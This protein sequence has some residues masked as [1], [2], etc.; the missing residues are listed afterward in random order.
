MANPA[1]L[2]NFM[3]KQFEFAAHIRNPENPAPA[4]VDERRMAVYRELFYNNIDDQLAN[5]FPVIRS[6]MNDDEWHAMVRD[7]YHRHDCHT[8]LFMEIPQEFISYI[9]LE[10]D[11]ANDYPFLLELAHYEW[12]ELALAVSDEKPDMNTIDLNGDPFTGIPAI[13]PVAWTLGYHYP[14]HKISK[15]LLPENPDD[16][17]THL[18]VYRDHKDDIHFMDINP[19]TARLMAL[20]AEDQRKTGEQ[21]LQA[22]ATEMQFPNPPALIEGGKTILQDMKNRGIIIGTLR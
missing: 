21:L 6:I 2:P 8:P 4:D 7:F 16:Q 5:A 10:R 17:M 20:I 19:V 3:R 11:N 15:D 1:T 13:S 14:V 22:I 9:E 12:V 18:I